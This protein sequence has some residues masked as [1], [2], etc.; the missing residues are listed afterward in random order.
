MNDLKL[1]A[2]GGDDD[3]KE[4]AG[5]KA[6]LAQLISA[7]FSDH[8]EV[9]ELEA[10]L[11]SEVKLRIQFARRFEEA[12]ERIRALNG[13]LAESRGE[14]DRLETQLDQLR[15]G[16]DK[17]EEKAHE[18]AEIGESVAREALDAAKDRLEDVME[19]CERLRTQVH[20]LAPFRIQ[21]QQRE[22]T[23]RQLRSQLEESQL[24]A[25]RFQAARD[26]LESEDEE[27]RLQAL[28]NKAEAAAEESETLRGKVEELEGELEMRIAVLDGLRED[29]SGSAELRTRMEE[30]RQENAQLRDDLTSAISRLELVQDLEGLEHMI[31]DA[32]DR[33][34][35]AERER[36]KARGD[37][38]R[39]LER[40]LVAEERVELLQGKLEDGGQVGGG[41]S[42]NWKVATGVLFAACVAMGMRLSTLAPPPPRLVVPPPTAPV[43]AL[44]D[45]EGVNVDVLEWSA[46]KAL[47][48]Q[49][50]GTDLPPP[51][52][53]ATRGDLNEYQV[54]LARLSRGDAIDPVLDRFH[55][56]ADEAADRTRRTAHVLARVLHQ[57]GELEAAAV[58]A[59]RALAID[60]KIADMHSVM[61][62]V[63]LAREDL[64]P[65]EA[66]FRRA[67]QLDAHL[68]RAYGGLAHVLELRGQEQEAL[69]SLG[70]ALELDPSNPQYHFSKAMTLRL[71]GEWRKVANHLKTALVNRPED[72]YSHWYL[73]EALGHL[74][75]TEEAQAHEAR[76]RELGYQDET[77]GERPPGPPGQE[78]PAP[79][80]PPDEAPAPGTGAARLPGM[81][82]PELPGTDA[83][84]PGLEPEPSP[85]PTQPAT[86]RAAPGAADP[87][88]EVGVS[89]TTTGN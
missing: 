5:E 16:I 82:G 70:K 24:Q 61:G 30:L 1:G 19:E 68:A 40:A 48:H 36:D 89:A 57:R 59:E 74:G 26:A 38:E 51:P 32:M 27:G 18:E 63:H 85:A 13:Q 35:E 15:S 41:A 66:S 79:T 83:P 67:I 6:R 53:E 31:N 81:D 76:A 75:E 33:A 22:G 28:R 88:A 2:V 73:A 47:D 39:Q 42:K 54:M 49:A 52:R 37:I 72:A 84:L 44:G 69:Q 45:G 71:H 17:L 58:L 7:E 43:M 56:I 50:A 86:D 23:I 80:G 4:E 64:A 20:E 34:E 12:S 3:D 62:Y 21:V 46:L 60:P 11:D 29:F 65:A 77:T 87:Y 10:R 25:E 8:K 78:P 55:Q 14:I 9:S